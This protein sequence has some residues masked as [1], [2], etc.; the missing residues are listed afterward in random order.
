MLLNLFNK[1]IELATSSSGYDFI[2]E[3]ARDLGTYR[4][5]FTYLKGKFE[6]CKP[7]YKRLSQNIEA[8]CFS[9]GKSGEINAALA[10][11]NLKANYKWSDR[12]ETTLQGGDK[13]IQVN[14]TELTPEEI[15][16]LNDELENDY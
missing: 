4:D 13:P 8:N 3:V 10:I 1:A 12:V 6:S 16:A 5:V 7:L 2:G 14:K 9:H 11:M 15:K